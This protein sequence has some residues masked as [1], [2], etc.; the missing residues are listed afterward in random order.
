LNSL[1]FSDIPVGTRIKIIS[2]GDNGVKSYTSQIS[3]KLDNG[4][5][6]AFTPLEKGRPVYFYE[7][8]ELDIY[9]YYKDIMYK[10]GVVCCDTY[11]K[12]F[13]GVVSLK[14]NTDIIKVEKRDFFR[15]E[16]SIKTAIEYED[17]VVSGITI[18][19]S[20]GGLCFKS[21]TKMG[22]GT[23]V[24]CTIELNG[25]MVELD[26]KVVWTKKSGDKYVS[27]LSFTGLDSR[28]Q[29]L[30]LNEVMRIQIHEL[31]RRRKQH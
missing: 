26:S 6:E 27:G 9:F 11:K 5:F 4:S 28:T 12:H 2:K 16:T 24:A 29:K 3:D 22:E 20:G 1:H 30:I 23:K 13:I 25:G 15:V 8:T 21:D 31:Q 7:G 10:V 19:L 14:Q 17:K 18:N